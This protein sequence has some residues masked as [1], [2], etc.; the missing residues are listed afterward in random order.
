[1]AEN[2]LDES[3]Y[4]QNKEYSALGVLGTN[5]KFPKAN[6]MVWMSASDNLPEEDKN[7]LLW[8]NGEPQVVYRDG[9]DWYWYHRPHNTPIEN[10]HKRSEYSD[11]T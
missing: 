9:N 11:P 6:V 3:L 10:S 7:V 1:M 8:Y 2:K 4:T 5:A